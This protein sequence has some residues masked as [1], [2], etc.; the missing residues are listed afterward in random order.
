[1]V[2][3]IQ[4]NRVT[5]IPTRWIHLVHFRRLISNPYRVYFH[6]RRATMEHTSA[7]LFS[8]FSSI[9]W[10][11]CSNY[12]WNRIK[13]FVLCSIGKKDRRM[14]WP[15]FFYHWNMLF[16]NQV[17]SHHKCKISHK[18]SI[19]HKRHFRIQFIRKYLC[20]LDNHK[21]NRAHTIQWII[22]TVSAIVSIS[23][24]LRRRCIQVW[25]L[26]WAWIWPCMVTEVKMFRCSALR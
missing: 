8:S 21:R 11:L 3:Q 20:R 10:K 16:W 12:I 9:K 18:I 5:G 4:I 17:Q 2:C 22:T 26:M 24:S 14:M 6:S 7:W 15:M 23:M 19:I 13:Q 25:V 1:M